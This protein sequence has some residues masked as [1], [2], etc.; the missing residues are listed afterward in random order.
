MSF[1]WV[2]PQ[3]ELVTYPPLPVKE[4]WGIKVHTK[5][6]YKSAREDSDLN[7]SSWGDIFA[8]GYNSIH[9]SVIRWLSVRYYEVPGFEWL[10][11]MASK[12][13][14]DFQKGLLQFGN[15]EELPLLDEL[16][17]L[18]PG[19][20]S[21]NNMD[22]IPESIYKCDLVSCTASD[23]DDED[24]RAKRIKSDTHRCDDDACPY[25]EWD[26]YLTK[27]VTLSATPDAFTNEWWHVPIEVKNRRDG[28]P[29]KQI[30]NNHLLQIIAQML[31]TGS[32]YCA[33]AVKGH[34]PSPQL[35][36]KTFMISPPTGYRASLKCVV[37][38]FKPVRIFLRYLTR[39]SIGYIA[40]VR[41][42]HK[43]LKRQMSSEEPSYWNRRVITD[44]IQGYKEYHG[45]VLE[46]I[47]KE[48]GVKSKQQMYNL[49]IQ[50]MDKGNFIKQ[51]EEWNKAMP[52]LDR[53]IA[54]FDPLRHAV[55]N[56]ASYT[57]PWC[58]SVTLAS[59]EPTDRRLSELLCNGCTLSSFLA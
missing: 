51:F 8:V 22:K 40:F 36:V 27:G 23:S 10:H 11:L 50:R 30:K 12:E 16:K 1:D 33:Y 28:P 15:D 4:Q 48:L 18:L 47:K 32:T 43:K 31:C 53:S 37:E 58:W 9:Y 6:D 17:V 56:T 3:E 14:T 34:D 41:D 7:A 20:H 59:M 35:S 2:L 24:R 5:E 52:D 21:N 13:E 44:T 57:K 26:A 54:S 29:Y 25:A 19:L 46:Q 45:T 42:A 39:C 55:V 38:Y 49:I